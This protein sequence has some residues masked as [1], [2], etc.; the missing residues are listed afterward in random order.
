MGTTEIH[1]QLANDLQKLEKK[2]LIF[3]I[4]NK[5]FPENVVSTLNAEV[6]RCFT[7]NNPDLHESISTGQK[8]CR[9]FKCVNKLADLRIAQCE[10]NMRN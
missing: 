6:V 10:I 7:E 3:Y 9:N 1:Q 8:V 4:I 5:Q 2:D